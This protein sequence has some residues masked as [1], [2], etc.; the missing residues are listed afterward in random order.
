MN[1]GKICISVCAKTT[2]DLINK[3]DAA[4]ELADLIE[5]RFDCLESGEIGAV[6]RWLSQSVHGNEIVTTFRPL[7]QGGHKELS[8]DDRRRFWGRSTQTHI[9]DIEADLAENIPALHYSRY[10][11]SF[12][13]FET[14]PVELNEIFEKLAS[15][16]AEILKI[17]AK[18]DDAVD[19]IPLWKLIKLSRHDGREIAPIGMGEAGKWTRILGLAHGTYLTYAA[20]NRG[21]ETAPG[22]ITAR[23]MKDVFRVKELN[24]QTEVYGIIAGDTT[25]SMSPYIH[26]AAFKKAEMNAVFVPF[27]VNDLDA[28]IMRMVNPDSREVELNFQG[29][30][31]T[32][33]HKQAIM[34]YLD[35]V[36]D[37]AAKIGAV[38]TVKILNGK[39]IGF[40]TDAHGFIT[41]LTKRF[42]ELSNARV[43][44][45]GAGGAARACTY[46]LKNHGADVT[47]FARD[48]DKAEAFST[49]F[50]VDTKKLEIKNS[51]PIT[52][53]SNFDVVVNTTPLGTRGETIASA[54][55]EKEQLRGVKLVYDLVYN[56]EETRLLHEAKQAGADTLGGFEM[57]IAQAERQFDIWTNR[58]PPVAEMRAAAKQKI[59]ER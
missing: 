17:A 18:A 51:R 30:S 57:L 29:F 41:P 7:E 45:V 6:D 36:D 48:I 35:S 56:P 11:C 27:Q 44:V 4:K 12:H 20:L 47:V 8:L 59:A 28:F 40:N 14:V 3:V 19:V 2:A 9:A 10:I 49:V 38:N 26:N 46:S 25:Y 13:D 32:N 34:R 31:V 15:S 33:P 5:I 37:S 1:N 52:D 24:E 53:F 54:I 55:A 42:P 16:G 22:Q 58:E 50:N 23:E 21:D 39:L 43:A